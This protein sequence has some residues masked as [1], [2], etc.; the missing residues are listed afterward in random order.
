MRSARP[1][2]RLVTAFSVV[3][4]CTSMLVGG[5]A[6]SAGAQVRGFDGT[7]V[8]VAGYGIKSQLP[9]AE[10]GAEARFK[11]FN[12]TNE[13]KGVKIKFAEFADD[14]QDPANTLSI[15]RRLVT[16]ENVF[17]I[18]PNMSATNNGQYLAQQ[19]VPSFG[20]GFDATYCSHEPSKKL[21]SFSGNGCIAPADPSFV[22]D[23]YK[24]AYEIVRAKTG[25]KHPSFVEVL[26]DTATG[27]NAV[28]IFAVAAQ[29]AGFNVVSS[30]ATLPPSD[31]SDYT[32]YVQQI[33]KADNGTPPDAINCSVQVECL[34][35]WNLLVA[36]GYKG[37]FFSSLYTDV[38]VKA[39]KDS[40]VLA[41]W[42]N[43]DQDVPAL[44]QL[45][46][47]MDAV[48][49][50][51]SSNIDTGVIYG[52]TSADMFIRALE[53]VAKKGKSNI[54]PVNVQKAASTMTWKLKGVMG[55][56]EYPKATVMYFPACFATS[57]SDGTTWNQV[58]PLSCS[59]KTYSPNM[60]VHTGS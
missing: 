26:N 41:S 43:V 46:A 1:V 18:V 5:V 12:D 36:S 53:Q 3:A 8:T 9:L 57:L 14:G 44:K 51:S 4:L 33:L 13:L 50:G 55:P 6:T 21:W 27:K 29:G 39:L 49:P 34:G 30:T 2:H 60:K 32:P 16:Q 40:Y 11:R 22:S 10:T 23:Y 24:P 47:D 37:Y 7:T 15:E 42:G 31:V 45:K 48:K 38:L 25:K 52:Y 58:K 17:A 56:V 59:T 20:G 35:L 28:K 19:H 54:T